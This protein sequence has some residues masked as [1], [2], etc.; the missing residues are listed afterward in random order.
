M[1]TLI[2]TFKPALQVYSEH[3]VLIMGDL[4][5]IGTFMH[6]SHSR[7]TENTSTWTRWGWGA[8]SR[9]GDL[10]S[11]SLACCLTRRVRAP[12][13]PQALS[14]RSPKERP[15][16]KP[17]GA[18]LLDLNRLHDPWARRRSLTPAPARRSSSSTP[19]LGCAAGAWP[20]HP[21]EA[22]PQRPPLGAP[23]ELGPGTRP[24]EL[25][26]STVG[27]GGCC[28]DWL[29]RE[30]NSLQEGCA[31]RV[32][33]RG[34]REGRRME[35]L[36][37][38]WARDWSGFFIYFLFSF[39]TKIYF[40]FGNLQKYTRPPGSRAAGGYLQKKEEKKL[41]AVHGAGRP[42]VGWPAPNPI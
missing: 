8:R 28:D 13:H 26:L 17:P 6:A 16:L 7:G 2:K 36:G 5:L 23:L 1:S 39:F 30:K 40:R 15:Q 29:R 32:D 11:R 33:L 9:R 19:A 12:A 34:W 4:E 41:Q 24:S 37:F 35:L 31:A 42:A 22:R 38:V 27:V 21:P 20:R 3:F 14:P 18:H 10:H 25:A